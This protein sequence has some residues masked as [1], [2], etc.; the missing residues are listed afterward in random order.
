MSDLLGNTSAI[1]GRVRKRIKV[2]VP[3]LT[4]AHERDG[5]WIGCVGKLAEAH[6]TKEFCRGA[7]LK[8]VQR[9]MSRDGVLFGDTAFEGNETFK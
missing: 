8:S 1:V 2:M 7:V 4:G 3:S 5:A 6:Q 9:T